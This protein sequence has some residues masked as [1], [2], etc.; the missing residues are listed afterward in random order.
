MCWR[1]VIELVLNILHSVGRLFRAKVVGPI[2]TAVLVV[3]AIISMTVS[4]TVVPGMLILLLAVVVFAGSCYLSGLL[5]PLIAGMRTPA[6][7][8]QG[9]GSRPPSDPAL[10]PAPIAAADPRTSP[11][12]L[13]EIARNFPGLRV[14]VALNP[15]AGPHTM[16]FLAGLRDPQVSA[17]LARRSPRA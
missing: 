15:S 10:P 6:P 3:L 7:A 2:V 12:H 4:Y 8:Q 16:A 13:D 14:A 17:A 11:H 1:S 9:P 5:T